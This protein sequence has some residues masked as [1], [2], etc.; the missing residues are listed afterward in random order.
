MKRKLILLLIMFTGLCASSYAQ[1]TA[2]KHPAHKPVHKKHKK[3]IVVE[4]KTEKIVIDDNSNRTVVEIKNGKVYVDGNVVS[5]IKN[6]KNEDHKIVINHK[7]KAGGKHE[8]DE[9]W[10]EHNE[11]ANND[12]PGY[13]REE[14]II[15]QNDEPNDRT[16]LSAPMESQPTQGMAY[17]GVTGNGSSVNGAQIATVMEG[18]PA[19]YAGL[20]EGDVI[21]NVNQ[22]DITSFAAL[23]STIANYQPGDMVLITYTRN[24]ET[25]QTRAKL[26]EKTD[27]LAQPLRKFHYNNQEDNMQE[28]I[29]SM[30]KPFHHYN[31]QFYNYRNN[32]G[33]NNSI[34]L[35]DR[36]NGMQNYSNED[37]MPSKPLR[38]GISATDARRPRGVYLEEVKP[39]GPAAMAGLQAG[40]VILRINDERVR[41]AY[42]MQE[43]LSEPGMGNIIT[44]Q[45]KHNGQKMVTE[46]RVEN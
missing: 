8:G 37:V 13:K 1:T 14:K 46:A 9:E 15:I 28:M 7:K 2:A 29:D 40:D 6:T 33:N 26:A 16:E 36:R 30:N 4:K 45:Y 42:E 17:L 3:H 10:K 34:M 21:T 24:G 43:L 18:S 20:Q 22:T 38:L 11:D 44:I 31:H 12:M 35:Y 27:L 23:R 25:A 19:A 32:E 39:N 5:Y 41:Y